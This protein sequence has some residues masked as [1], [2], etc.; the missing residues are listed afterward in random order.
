MLNR[1]LSATPGCVFSPLWSNADRRA[2]FFALYLSGGEHTDEDSLLAASVAWEYLV[3]CEYGMRLAV[4]S[5]AHFALRSLIN[6]RLAE[7]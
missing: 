2:P 6:F 3:S 5:K 1:S 7:I 4:A